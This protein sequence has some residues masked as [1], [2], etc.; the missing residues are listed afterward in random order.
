MLFPADDKAASSQPAAQRTDMLPA[1]VAVL[2]VERL[3]AGAAVRPSLLHDVALAS[4]HGLALEAAEV[5]HVPVATL[6]LGALIGKDDLR[7]ENTNERHSSQLRGDKTSAGL[8]TR[9]DRTKR[10]S[11]ARDPSL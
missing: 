10:F 5:L 1:G 3:E 7:E 2:G 8:L 4:Q 9:A 11:S 6:G